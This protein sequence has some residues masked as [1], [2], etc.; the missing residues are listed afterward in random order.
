MF[1]NFSYSCKHVISSQ[2]QYTSHLGKEIRVKGLQ[3]LLCDI[4]FSLH[5]LALS[6]LGGFIFGGVLL[7]LEQKII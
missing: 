1:C 3:I 7:T 6:N 2:S 5:H 4:T